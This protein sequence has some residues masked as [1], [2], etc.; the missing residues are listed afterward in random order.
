MLTSRLYA[1]AER[2]LGKSGFWTRFKRD[3]EL[4]DIDVQPAQIVL[5][6]VLGV[7]VVGWLFAALT[8]FPLLA[9]VGLSVLLVPRA[10]VQS[11]VRKRKLAFAEQ[12]PDNLQVMA[13]AMR[14]GHSFIGALSVVVNDSPEPSA[15]E[16]RRAVADEQLGVPLEE[17]L[18]RVVDRM[19]NRDLGQVALVAAMQRETGGNTA[20]VLER[21]TETIR[22]RFELRR[23]VKTLTAQ[24]RMSRWVV[25]ALPIFLLVIITLINP[26]YM[27]PLY[28]RPLGRVL[29]VGAAGLVVAGSLVIKR[30]VDIKV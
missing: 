1:G 6:T 23:L 15:S 22:E 13:S 30:I 7:I 12:L 14:A 11:R 28:D 20:E 2:S 25:S 27:Q 24:G 18:R 8:G 10:F 19:D 4:G 16:F 5:A 3:L 9:L 21:V 29:L 17:A 26:T